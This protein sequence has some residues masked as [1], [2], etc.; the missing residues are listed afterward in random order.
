MQTY[1]T[2]SFTAIADN[3]RPVIAFKDTLQYIL[4]D[5]LRLYLSPLPF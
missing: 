1:F 5:R 2:S 4:P 3:A